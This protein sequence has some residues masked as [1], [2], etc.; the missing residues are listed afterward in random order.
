[1]P[2]TGASL[3]IVRF[4]YL[5]ETAN[6][7]ALA[8]VEELRLQYRDETLFISLSEHL[9]PNLHRMSFHFHGKELLKITKKEV[10]AFR[11]L[12]KA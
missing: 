6:L 2:E 3:R 8:N 1:M 12:R 4:G 10:K 11:R 9:P 7:S 5:A